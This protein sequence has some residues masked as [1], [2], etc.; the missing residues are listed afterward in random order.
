MFRSLWLF[1]R[2]TDSQFTHVFVIGLNVFCRNHITRHTLFVGSLDDL[3]IHIREILHKGHVI[4]TRFQVTT[5]YVEHQC[6]AR[7]TDVTIVIDRHTTDVHPNFI[8]FDQF[9]YFLPTG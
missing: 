2:D 5:K 7:M 9:E 4:A 6:A 1:C 3:V 8:R